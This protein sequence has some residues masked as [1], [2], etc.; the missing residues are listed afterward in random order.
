[1][2]QK[3]DIR[4]ILSLTYAIEF[5]VVVNNIFDFYLFLYKMKI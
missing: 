5:I 1:M 3:R 4:T 2:Q